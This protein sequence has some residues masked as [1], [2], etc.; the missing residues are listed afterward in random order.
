M[1]N[2]ACIAN[3][4]PRE[5][6]Q[7]WIFGILFFVIG[8]TT[9]GFLKWMGVGS[10]WRVGLFLPFWLGMLGIFQANSQTCVFLAAQGT[11]QI[12][13]LQAK[14]NDPSLQTKIQHQA[15]MVYRKTLLVATL[16]TIISILL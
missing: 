8:L 5:R 6:R 11:R 3:I 2:V 13:G 12:E 16:M 4:G 9:A 15:Q 1:S 7:R 10:A 14:V